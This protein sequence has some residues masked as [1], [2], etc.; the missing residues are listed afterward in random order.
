MGDYKSQY[1]NYYSN[2]KTNSSKV[3]KGQYSLRSSSN[4]NKNNDEDVSKNKYLKKSSKVTRVYV[5]M[6]RLKMF[7]FCKVSLFIKNLKDGGR[8]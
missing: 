4:N 8:I 7:F 1:E 6:F 3:S 5:E 2:I